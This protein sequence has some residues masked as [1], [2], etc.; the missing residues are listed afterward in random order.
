MSKDFIVMTGMVV[1]A[2][3]LFAATLYF[4]SGVF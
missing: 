4:R 2:I 3:V 1:I